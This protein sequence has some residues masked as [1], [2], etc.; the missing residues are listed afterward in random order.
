MTALTSAGPELSVAILGPVD[1]RV[2]GRPLPIRSA[3]MRCLLAALAMAASR[4]VPVGRLLH[5]LW[6]EQPPASAQK[7]LHQ[8]VHRLRR[9]LGEHGAADRLQWH[10]AGYRLHLAPGELDLERF[11]TLAGDG[12]RDRLRGD[13]PAAVRA[14]SAA[15]AL[16][17]DDPF[18]DLRESGLLDTV[19]R[20]LEAQRLAVLEER[21]SVEI[22]LGRFGGLDA[23]LAGLVAGYPLRERFR[24]LRMAVLAGTGRRAEA[25]TIYQECRVTLARELG[26]DPG[27]AITERMTAILRGVGPLAV[28]SRA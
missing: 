24:E 9:Q 12:R 5:A 28:P 2:A 10:P 25:L 1:L 13:R 11:E 17:R 18:A 7:N 3:K 27:P 26:I 6:A 14:F 19:A 16:W 15:L 8:Y 21:I 4:P 22:E 20:T 23:E